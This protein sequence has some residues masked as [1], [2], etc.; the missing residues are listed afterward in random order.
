[1]VS[2]ANKANH[3][4]RLLFGAILVFAFL[5]RFIYI[6]DIPKGIN[7]DEAMA[8]M[9]AWALSKYGTDRYGMQLP[10]HF[11]AWRYGQMSVL[12]SYCM[13]PFIKLFGFSTITVRIPMVIAGTMGILLVYLIARKFFSI[14]LSRYSKDLI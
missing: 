12:L 2:N 5:I 6:A 10:V 14:N 13:I 3:Y 1:M 9:D 4:Q 11:Q 8:A 7:Q